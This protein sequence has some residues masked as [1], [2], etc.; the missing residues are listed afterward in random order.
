MR[1]PAFLAVFILAATA[2]GQQPATTPPENPFKGFGKTGLDQRKPA[3]AQ[4]LPPKTTPAAPVSPTQKPFAPV[5]GSH[6]GEGIVLNN[7]WQS[8]LA[9]AAGGQAMKIADLRALLKDFGTA[10]ADIAAHPEVTVYEGQRMDGNP[11]DNCRIPYLM[12]LP[13]AEAALLKSRGIT[14]ATRAVAPGLP[15]GLFIHTYDVRAGI[16]NRLCIVTD[17]A[18]PDPQ[19]VSI[20]LKA[21]GVNYYPPIPFRKI[22]RNWHTFDYINTEN[23][24]QGSVQI[25][26]RVNDLLK[27]KHHIVVN[28][29]GGQYP[30]L[31]PPPGIILKPA[32]NSPKETTTW[33]VPA[34]LIRLMLYCLDNQSPQ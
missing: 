19:V 18:K 34:P 2:A 5:T 21:E 23:R 8:H 7:A 3:P 17:G 32:K 33:Y 1:F 22:L 14:T 20:L 6:T 29:T 31:L 24:G 12:P 10:Q 4:G 16:Y 27:E 28:T 13:Q 25:D 11:G 9:Q 26:T 30:D 15:D